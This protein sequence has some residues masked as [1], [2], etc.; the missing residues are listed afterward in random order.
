MTMCAPLKVP[1]GVLAVI[2]AGCASQEERAAKINHDFRDLNLPLQLEV[3]N[4][5]VKGDKLDIE[6]ARLEGKRHGSVRLSIDQYAVETTERAIAISDYIYRGIS[7]PEASTSPAS[8]AKLL[9]LDKRLD[10]ITEACHKGVVGANT[11]AE[12][13]N[14]CAALDSAGSLGAAP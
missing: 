4:L 14:A 7:Q 12:A 10:E 13:Q 5:R 8:R 3:D 11:L 2:L 9:N 6:N 1:L